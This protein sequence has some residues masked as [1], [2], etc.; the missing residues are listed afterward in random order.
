[1]RQIAYSSFDS[2]RE[3]T[4]PIETHLEDWTDPLTNEPRYG[5]NTL[6]KYFYYV[7]Q[8]L[9]LPPLSKELREKFADFYEEAN[10]N[11]SEFLVDGRYNRQMAIN[12]RIRARLLLKTEADCEDLEEAR[13]IVNAS[14]FVVTRTGVIDVA[15]GKEELDGNVT[16]GVESKSSIKRNESKDRQFMEAISYTMTQKV[17]E[18]QPP[19]TYFTT[20]D[21]LYYF[22]I[23]GLLGWDEHEVEKIVQRWMNVN[24][25]HEMGA[26]GGG[27]YSL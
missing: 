6:R 3:S 21:I 22:K 16:V 5:F 17:P 15:T 10:E 8:M 12:A 20:A 11:S 24:K 2:Y 18:G 9:Q 25:L 19:R 1:L 23:K 4:D 14:K 7:T 26:P 27:R 13:R